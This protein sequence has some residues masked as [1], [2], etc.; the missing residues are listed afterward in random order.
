L[1]K[2]V[3]NLKEWKVPRGKTFAM[4]EEQFLRE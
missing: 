1:E 4:E 3:P 2:Q